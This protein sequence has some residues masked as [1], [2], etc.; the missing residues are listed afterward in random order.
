MHLQ[1]VSIMPVVKVPVVRK[2][3]VFSQ[4]HCVE[5]HRQ[6]MEQSAPA[7]ANNVIWRLY[8]LISLALSKWIETYFLFAFCILYPLPLKNEC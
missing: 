5:L 7:S 1:F 2:F 3:G 6:Q 4:S 8:L